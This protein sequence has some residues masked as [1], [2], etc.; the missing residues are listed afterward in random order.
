ML[1]LGGFEVMPE[2]S[3]ASTCD[4]ESRSKDGMDALSDVVDMRDYPF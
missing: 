1:L 4:G 2:K 3:V